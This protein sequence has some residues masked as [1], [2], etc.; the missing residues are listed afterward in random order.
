[1]FFKRKRKEKDKKKEIDM[2]YLNK[3]IKL[4]EEKENNI[5]RNCNTLII[6]NSIIL[7][8]IIL[9]IIIG[10]K[11]L[12]SVKTLII[13]FGLIIV[14]LFLISN[15]FSMLI[16]NINTK[17]DDLS[18]FNLKDIYDIKNRNNKRKDRLLFV[19]HILSCSTYILIYIF[20]MVILIVK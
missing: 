15:V 9:S 7:I 12:N 11:E 20:I 10:I 4:E 8:P 1:M 5:F 6:S 16:M 3:A 19:S 18:S 17:I 2:E 14:G 13:I